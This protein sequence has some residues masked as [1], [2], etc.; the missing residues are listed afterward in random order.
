M[1]APTAPSSRWSGGRD[2]PES[3]FNRVVPGPAPAGLGLQAVRLSRG[4]ARGQ[5]PRHPGR[6]HARSRST[7]GGRATSEPLSGPP[8]LRTAFAQSLNAAAVRL[9]ERSAT[10][11]SSRGPEMG[12]GSPL[13]RHPSLALGGDGVT[14]L[15]LTRAYARPRQCAAEVEPFV[16]AQSGTAR[17]RPS[18][19]R[20]RSSG[21]AGR[22]ARSSAAARGHALRHRQRAALDRR[23]PA[24]QGPARTTAMPGSSASPASSCRRVGRQRRRHGRCAASPA[25]AAGP[26]L[27]QLRGG[28]TR[29]PP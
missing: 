20:R 23:W 28:R 9:Q 26:D 24:R 25:A 18:G 2:Y 8:E 7:N 14:L 3:Q 19:A 6:G 29:R 22:A 21:G 16:M 4:A 5:H 12:I 13:R 11:G 10:S 1:P 27:A 17:P 15:E